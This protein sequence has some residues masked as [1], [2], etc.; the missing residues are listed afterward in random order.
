[1]MNSQTK[2]LAF[3]MLL[4]L[5]ACGA[6]IVQFPDDAGSTVGVSTPD[7]GTDDDGGNI[8]L[9]DGGDGS[10]GTTGGNTNGGTTGANSGGTNGGN[11]TGT[12][13][14]GGTT[15]GGT[16]GTTTVGGTTTGGTTGTTTVGG[17]TTGGT[18]GTTT[19][20]GT[21]TGGTTGAT[22][23]GTNGGTTNGGTTGVTNGGTTA[24]G[25]T[26]GTTGGTTGGTVDIPDAGSGAVL[27]DGGTTCAGN[28][29]D[30][31]VHRCDVACEEGHDQARVDC[32]D[33]YNACTDG[34]TCGAD[35]YN[36]CT[37]TWNTCLSNVE[38]DRTSCKAACP[39]NANG[40]RYYVG[41]KID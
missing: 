7:S 27:P 39:V 23:G 6:Q 31:R 37:N 20:G 41:L 32:D 35:Q 22:N 34:F 25:T 19:V 18:T 4:V 2:T 12:T 38:T 10:V 1:M 36:A 9:S 21:T 29:Y 11:T 40:T 28:G 8:D 5:T 24:G 30:C 17:T 16:T 15:S 33:Q 14:V 13:T 3:M 26:A